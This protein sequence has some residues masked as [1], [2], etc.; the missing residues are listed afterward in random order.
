MEINHKVKMGIDSWREFSDDE[1]ISLAYG[2]VTFLS[3]RPN[4][5]KHIY[6]EDVL[7]KYAPS[8]LGKFVV[9][10]FD[11]MSSDTTTHTKIKI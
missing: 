2:K 1:D 7:K 10:E 5:H 4:S 6:T 8:Y 9:A 11:S 3:T